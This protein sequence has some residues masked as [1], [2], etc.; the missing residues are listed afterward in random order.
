MLHRVACISV[1]LAVGATSAFALDPTPF[2]RNDVFDDIKISPTGEYIAATIPLDDRV[3]LAILRTDDKSVTGRVSLGPNTAISGFSWVNDERVVLGVAERFGSRDQPYATGELV[4]VNADGGRDELL[5]GW[6]ATGAAVGTRISAKKGDRVAAFMV[7]T[8]PNDE[9]WAVIT[10]QPFT[11]D[12]FRKLE[13]MDVYTGRRITIGRAPI[14]NASFFTDN[15]GVTRFAWGYDVD[16]V[17]KLFYRG[18]DEAEWIAVPPGA[19]GARE[20]PVG[21]SADNRLA[22]LLTERNEGPNVLVEF[23]PAS[24]SRRIVLQDDNTSPHEILYRNDSQTPIGATFMDGLPRSEFLDPKAPESRLLRSLQAAFPGQYV[25]VTSTTR[26][27]TRALVEVRSDRNAGDFYLFDTVNK[28]VDFLLARREWLDPAKMAEVRPVSMT[29]R[30]GLALQGYLTLPPGRGEKNL[31]MVV[32]PHGGPFE[33]Y[34]KW[35]FEAD[36]QL[37]AA[38][39]YAVLQPNFRGSGNHGRSFQHAG[40][41]QWGKAMQ[42]DVTDATR[43]AI[44]QGIADKGRICIHGA[45][46]G[47]Y[48]ALMGA[49]RE[50]DLYRCASG[51]VGVYNLEMMHRT[52]DIQSSRSGETYLREWIGERKTLKDVSPVYLADRI[53]VPVLLSG[54]GEDVRTPVEH[55][56]LMEKAIERAGGQVE[57]IYFKT[58]GHGYYDPE[59]RK[60]YYSRL[61]A[62]LDKHLGA[63]GTANSASSG[64]VEP[65]DTAAR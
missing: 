65:V 7:D 51:Y 54:G 20:Y 27:G 38:A 52:G 24:S 14:L 4:G 5:V 36:A 48:A 47:A 22:Y 10:T 50:P 34:D 16:L 6:R 60:A 35:T 1:L 13:R 61:L 11:D 23:D 12:P 19:D 2:V 44:E 17:N 59:N 8:L 45:S 32:M 55:T 39:G 46:Y 9:R 53:K 64:A 26:D 33:I 29:A 21:F 41:R 56:E 31:P 25:R 40:A 28:K 3:A 30:D 18:D 63:A 42:D 57:S 62:F 49:V 15:A 37:L 43:W 58:E